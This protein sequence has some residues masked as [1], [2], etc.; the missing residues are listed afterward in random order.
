MNTTNGS[1]YGTNQKTA[2]LVGVLFIIGTAAGVTSALVTGPVL[3]GPV[4]LARLAANGG[5]LVTGA[6][7]VLTMGLALAM[8]PVLLFPLFRKINE[9]LALGYVVFRGALETATCL[10]WAVSWLLL[11][12]LGREYVTV[13]APDTTHFQSLS[14]LIQA[15]GTWNGHVGAIFF[16]LGALM[17][18]ALFYRSQLLPRWLSAWGLLGAV[19]YLAVPLSAMLGSELEI[20][21]GPLLLQELVMAIWLIVKGFNRAAMAP[22]PA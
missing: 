5:P 14:T 13:G 19:L 12:S 15:A 8:V 17:L 4:D 10:L 16:S 9:P 7:L 6:L 21:Y 3:S 1:L 11:I 2:F 18:Y 22:E 20:L